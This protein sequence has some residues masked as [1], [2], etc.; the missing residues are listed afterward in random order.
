M[1]TREVQDF[2]D[3]KEKGMQSLMGVDVDAVNSN[4]EDQWEDEPKSEE[5][6][7]FIWDVDERNLNEMDFVAQFTDNDETDEPEDETDE[8]G[9]SEESTPTT[10][11]AQGTRNKGKGI[12]TT[13]EVGEESS[14][15]PETLKVRP[16]KKPSKLQI[17][18]NELASANS[19]IEKL[20]IYLDEAQEKIAAQEEALAAPAPNSQEYLTVAHFQPQL[21]SID[22]VINIFYETPG[23]N[24]GRR[25]RRREETGEFQPNS[26]DRFNYFNFQYMLNLRSMIL[27]ALQHD[28]KEKTREL[29]D[30]FS[31]WHNAFAKEL[32]GMDVNVRREID[33]SRQ[34]LEA[35]WHYFHNN[36]PAK[37]AH[38]IRIGYREI[39]AVDPNPRL[40]IYLRLGQRLHRVLK[41]Q[42]AE[43]L[44]QPVGGAPSQP[45]PVD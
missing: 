13:S 37:A 31:D 35:Y 6:S 7:E 18:R 41:L 10:S 3:R 33:G 8:P 23:R 2:Q 40:E 25:S 14:K 20:T 42:P 17:V 28:S 27:K 44:E 9:D 19:Q 30:S 24:D 21:T 32:S 34:V 29:L 11:E 12:A 39:L 5:S 1:L 43:V 26:A 4:S 36:D 38:A 16:R 45:R 22:D 15:D